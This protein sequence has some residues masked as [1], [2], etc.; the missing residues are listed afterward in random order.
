MERHE[1]API[2]RLPF[3]AFPFRLKRSTFR[4]K[5][6]LTLPTPG[7]RLDRARRSPGEGN[8]RGKIGQIGQHPMKP[9]HFLALATSIVAALAVAA[10]VAPAL[11]RAADPKPD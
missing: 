4:N 1:S 5:K 9:K 11:L 6:T 7:V 2:H 8:Q 10:L 3:R